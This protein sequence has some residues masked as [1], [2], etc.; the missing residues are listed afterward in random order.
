[1][2]G[3]KNTYGQELYDEDEDGDGVE[4]NLKFTSH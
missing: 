3:A 2:E 1:M 4:D